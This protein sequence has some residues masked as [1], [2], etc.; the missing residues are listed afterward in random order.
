ME[1]K[2]RNVVITIFYALVVGYAMS[3]FPE[4]KELHSHFF[5]CAYLLSWLLFLT[6]YLVDEFASDE[7]EINHVDVKFDVGGWLLFAAVFHC[8]SM[9]WVSLI[10]GSIGVLLV[11]VPLVR[12]IFQRCSKSNQGGVG[13]CHHCWGPLLCDKWCLEFKWIIENIIFIGFMGTLVFV[14]NCPIPLGDD[15][16][17]VAF[18]LVMLVIGMLFGIKVSSC[19]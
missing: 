10:F 17:G 12:R 16:R 8:H 19:K 4:A 3:V 7:N 1:N 11:S 18:G 5:D 9:H 14:H 2:E 15:S 13:L 6:A